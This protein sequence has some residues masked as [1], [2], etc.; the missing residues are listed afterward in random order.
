M[1]PESGSTTNTES[2]QSVAIALPSNNE[3]AATKA[4][5]TAPK[6]NTALEASES[7]RPIQLVAIS[8]EPTLEAHTSVPQSASRSA[9]SNSNSQAMRGAYL[10]GS[11]RSQNLGLSNG[12]KVISGDT[13][14]EV[15][16]YPLFATLANG[17]YWFA[18]KRKKRA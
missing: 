9:S 14:P 3:A 2:S 18:R 17:A 12:A 11:V 8:P 16:F 7:S 10:Q 15:L 13:G 6:R 4:H 5:K 1:V